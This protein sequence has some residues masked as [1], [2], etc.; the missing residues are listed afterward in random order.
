MNHFIFE[1][2]LNLTQEFFKKNLTRK[3]NKIKTHVSMLNFMQFQDEIVHLF[4][5]RSSSLERN[6]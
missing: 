4:Y 3:L 6:S 2:A 5:L 1:N